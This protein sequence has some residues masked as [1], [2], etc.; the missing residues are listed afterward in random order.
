MVSALCGYF[1]AGQGNC[2]HSITETA[3]SGAAPP[4]KGPSARSQSG[5][6]A[7]ARSERF[8]RTDRCE[9]C[10]RKFFPPGHVKSNFVCNLGQGDRT[11]LDPRLPRLRFEE[12]CALLRTNTLWFNRKFRMLNLALTRKFTMECLSES[13]L[14]SAAR[15]RGSQQSI[16]REEDRPPARENDFQQRSVRQIRNTRCERKGRSISRVRRQQLHRRHRIV[17]RRRFC[18]SVER[19]S[20]NG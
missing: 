4:A 3:N 20:K 16:E 7:S 2:Y 17:C 13:L 6:F 9:D 10:E 19:R 18:A 11:K 15:S 1:F 12:A 5:I 8:Q 14:A